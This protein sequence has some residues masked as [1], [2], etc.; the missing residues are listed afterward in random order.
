MNYSPT[1][2]RIVISKDAVVDQTSTWDSKEDDT[3]EEN[4]LETLN[5]QKIAL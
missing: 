5:D 2:K 4:V 3:D 1:M